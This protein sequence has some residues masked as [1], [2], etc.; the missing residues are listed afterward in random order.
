MD[1]THQAIMQA[2]HIDGILD[3]LFLLN[4]FSKLV[5]DGLG[6][7]R[8]GGGGGGEQAPQLLSTQAALCVGPLP[9]CWTGWRFGR[10]D[11]S[12]PPRQ[13]VLEAPEGCA[14]LMS[15]LNLHQQSFPAVQDPSWPQQCAK[16]SL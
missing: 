6:N 13:A 5:Q 15:G 3:V 4:V 16:C 12:S 14:N 1:G 8:V 7:A 9:A 11:I 2:A 10:C